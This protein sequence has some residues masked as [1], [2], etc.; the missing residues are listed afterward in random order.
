MQK[1]RKNYAFKLIGIC[2]LLLRFGFAVEA[3]DSLEGI[4]HCC[5]RDSL[6]F[7]ETDGEFYCTGGT[8]GIQKFNIECHGLPVVVIDFDHLDEIRDLNEDYCYIHH[9]ENESET[10]IIAGIC[11][12]QNHVPISIHLMPISFVFL[13]LTFVIYYKVKTLR[14]P[15]DIAFMISV[16]CLATFIV[17]HA[18]HHWL[19]HV[20]DLHTFFSFL[21]LYIAQYA[22][23]AYFAWLNV[24]MA[25]QL[26][27]NM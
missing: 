2:A 19:A 27:K 4:K 13:V 21:D 15:E 12:E 6:N 10:V 3:D 8:N 14:A 17:I 7:T 24:I 11:L 5:L 25:N 16:L 22:I 9:S 1:L 26:R 23:V 20:H 18:P